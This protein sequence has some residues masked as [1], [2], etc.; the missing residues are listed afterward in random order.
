MAKVEDLLIKSGFKSRNK[1]SKAYSL[2]LFDGYVLDAEPEFGD[3]CDVDSLVMRLRAKKFGR[4][5]NRLF[6]NTDACDFSDRMQKNNN[7]GF[8]GIATVLVEYNPEPSFFT[9]NGEIDVERF[10]RR[11]SLITS[12]KDI[13]EIFYFEKTNKLLVMIEGVWVQ[14]FFMLETNT[15]IKEIEEQLNNLCPDF[16]KAEKKNF[17]MKS[18]RSFVSE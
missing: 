5:M 9:A 8:I 4:F 7:E 6:T 18:L 13:Y 1:K 2:E 11:L 12:V 16:A 17:D 14:L 3:W 15:D 10:L